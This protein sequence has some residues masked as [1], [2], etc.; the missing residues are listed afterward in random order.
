MSWIA[1]EAGEFVGTALKAAGPE[2]VAGVIRAVLEHR[3]ETGKPN[4]DFQRGIAD[5]DDPLGLFVR[6][7]NN[8]DRAGNSGQNEEPNKD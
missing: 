6:P 4:E 1:R 2:F 7:K 8:P 3:G 5:A